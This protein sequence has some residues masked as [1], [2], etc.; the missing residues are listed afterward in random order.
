MTER[1]V[2]WHSTNWTIGIVCALLPGIASTIYDAIL[3]NPFFYTTGR[4]FNSFWDY[5]IYAMKFEIQAWFIFTLVATIILVRRFIYLPYQKKPQTTKP[6]PFVNYK[7][8][9]L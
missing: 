5:L 7:E 6:P 4:F 3:K 9:R 1:K 8:D 2:K